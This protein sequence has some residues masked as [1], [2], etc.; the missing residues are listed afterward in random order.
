M[1]VCVYVHFLVLVIIIVFGENYLLSHSTLSAFTRLLSYIIQKCLNPQRKTITKVLCA[2]ASI[3]D[4][5]NKN[6]HVSKRIQNCRRWA[7]WNSVFIFV[8][9]P[10]IFLWVCVSIRLPIVCVPS[11]RYRMR[12]KK[13]THAI[14][15]AQPTRQYTHTHTNMPTDSRIG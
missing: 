2:V 12:L 7:E 6:E 10:F 11:K 3:S 5:D 9:S 1:C 13:V 4:S 14:L 15:H 8:R